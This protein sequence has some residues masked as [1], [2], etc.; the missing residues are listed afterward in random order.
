MASACPSFAAKASMTR[1]RVLLFRS[2]KP[3]TRSS[4]CLQTRASLANDL[5]VLVVVSS[6]HS[7][8]PA[9]A[10]TLLAAR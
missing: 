10:G 4:P 8:E 7:R 9:L 3:S 5:T 1:S 6:I 2:L